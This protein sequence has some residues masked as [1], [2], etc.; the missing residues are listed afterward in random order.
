[1][2]MTQGEASLSLDMPGLEQSTTAILF[3]A[4]C[5]TNGVKAKK[6]KVWGA[7]GKE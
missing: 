4:Q 5:I 3:A 7:N 2:T 1:M 6:K